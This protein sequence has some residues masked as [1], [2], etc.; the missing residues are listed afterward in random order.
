MTK[1]FAVL[2]VVALLGTAEAVSYLS[3]ILNYN[4]PVGKNEVILTATTTPTY[5]KQGNQANWGNWTFNMDFS[6]NV[7]A[8]VFNALIYWSGYVNNATVY[9][10]WMLVDGG[11][12]TGTNTANGV[13]ITKSG[14]TIAGTWAPGMHVVGY[15][16][17]ISI[18]TTLPADISYNFQFWVSGDIV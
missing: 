14:G 18:G 3:T 1:G 5:I 4:V 6:H 13:L 16:V 2:L 7:S 12:V 17:G 11:V 15:D 8:L 10:V 9:G